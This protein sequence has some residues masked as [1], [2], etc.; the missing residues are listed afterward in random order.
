M[1]EIEVRDKLIA[2]NVAGQRVYRGLAPHGTAYPY[3]RFFVDK[4]P[5]T[6]D[7]QT[8][9][10]YRNRFQFQVY[11]QNFLDCKN[12]LIELQASMKTIGREL[13]CNEDEYPDPDTG[14][15]RIISEWF[16]NEFN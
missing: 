8:N 15:V 2:D 11:G 9:D 12:T 14:N 13:Y 4:E 1:N 16:V 7:L 10:S 6:Q 5:L 3:V